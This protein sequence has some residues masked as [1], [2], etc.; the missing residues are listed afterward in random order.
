MLQGLMKGEGLDAGRLHV[1]TLMRI[2]GIEAIYRH[3][4]TSKPA[5]GQHRPGI[6]VHFGGLHGGAEESRDRD[7]DGRQGR[8]AG[9]C[10][11]RT[12]LAVAIKYEDVY[13][14]AY[15]TV[16]EARA[17]IG[18]Y[19]TFCNTRRPHSS[20][21]RQTPDQAYFNVLTSMMVAA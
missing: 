2:M 20:L 5:P 10:L 16:S 21:D 14:H 1:A 19:L 8:V 3:P 17:A 6:A 18:R 9:Q 15:K 11:R 12:A 7:R 4:N 13:L